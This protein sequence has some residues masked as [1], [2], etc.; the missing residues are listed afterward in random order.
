M[1]QI[2]GT[3][4]S[5]HLPTGK[6]APMNAPDKFDPTEFAERLALT[7]EPFPASKKIYASGSVHADLRVP[8]REVTLT[9]G[10][11]GDRVV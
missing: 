9:N 3:F 1:T 11:R 4:R 8:M 5:T 2:Q 10:W 7:R 6:D